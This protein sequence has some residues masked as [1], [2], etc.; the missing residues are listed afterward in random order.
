[1]T[2]CHE[3]K[4]ICLSHV[5]AFEENHH[6]HVMCMYIWQQKRCQASQATVHDGRC[7]NKGRGWRNLI[8][9]L[10]SYKAQ[11]V[12]Q[13][14]FFALQN[15]VVFGEHLLRYPQW[16]CRWCKCLT[17]ISLRVRQSAVSGG[18]VLNKYDLYVILSPAPLCPRSS[19]SIRAWSQ[20]PPGSRQ[21]SMNCCRARVSHCGQVTN[22][23]VKF[24]PQN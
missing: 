13:F 23:I 14:N 16:L 7:T 9:K 12:V 1:M 10:E 24:F 21:W 17:A 3:Q 19:C 4:A 2:K 8:K 6:T 22:Q 5:V 11:C 18:N 15:D 20:R